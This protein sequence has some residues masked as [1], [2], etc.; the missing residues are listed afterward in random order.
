MTEQNPYAPPQTD[1]SADAR[2]R[3]DGV[4]FYHYRVSSRSLVNIVPI[5]FVA[6]MSVVYVQLYIKKFSIFE[7]PLPAF[8]ICVAWLYLL[9]ITIR[10]RIFE[11]RVGLETIQWQ[12]P[13]PN[14]CSETIQVTDI[15][16]V[17][18]EGAAISIETA[19]GRSF[20]PSP[21]C[22]GHASREVVDAITSA[23]R[24]QLPGV[25]VRSH[26]T[27]FWR[28]LGKAVGGWIR[29]LSGGKR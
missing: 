28:S 9:I 18:F 1:L 11:L 4:C 14:V 13:W 5:G 24:Y 3:D 7:F 2:P 10:P 17:T 26:D 8:L 23:V 6:W 29:W 22:Y 21:Y 27:S 12:R 25:Q 20:A 15:Q 19:A 16:K